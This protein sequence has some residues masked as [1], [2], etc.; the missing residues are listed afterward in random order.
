M[1]NYRN[2]RVDV[3]NE[4]LAN[5]ALN[6]IQKNSKT[7]EDLDI[8][9]DYYQEEYEDYLEHECYFS[10]SLSMSK[11]KYLNVDLSHNDESLIDIL[12]DLLDA[13]D[14][15]ISFVVT[16]RTSFDPAKLANKSKIKN[17]TISASQ[18]GPEMANAK[19][20]LS[21][22]YMTSFGV[23]QLEDMRAFFQLMAPTLKILGCTNLVSAVLF[24]LVF[25]LPNLSRLTFDIADDDEIEDDE[26]DFNGFVWTPLTS[27]RSLKC[28]NLNDS[29]KLL[30][31][32]SLNNLKF[33]TVNGIVTKIIS[34]GCRK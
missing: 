8:C 16:D 33:L 3:E 25:L 34:K 1:R 10:E 21:A 18:I 32:R 19:F 22:L 20:R 5:F 27:V 23:S 6:L 28:K 31:Q 4:S 2:L 11:L 26:S 29:I 14:N 13:A 30:I 17:L 7:L 9:I 12:N 15:L 24:R